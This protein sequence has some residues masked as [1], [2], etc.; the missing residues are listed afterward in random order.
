MCFLAIST[1]VGVSIVTEC[2][3]RPILSARRMA[4][5]IYLS[6]VQA[7]IRPTLF[8]FTLAQPHVL[9]QAI[10]IVKGPYLNHDFVE[11]WTIYR[12]TWFFHEL[13]WQITALRDAFSVLILTQCS[14]CHNAQ[15]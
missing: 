1:R 5:H 4:L 12:L 15:C 9:M 8:Q 13:W 3:I 10:Y 6:E 7:F 2:T 11:I 14:S